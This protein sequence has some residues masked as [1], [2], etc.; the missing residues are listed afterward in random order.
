MKTFSKLE[1]FGWS[2]SV[3]TNFGGLQQLPLI[4]GNLEQ[5]CLAG[6]YRIAPLKF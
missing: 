4:V 5:F 6:L 2:P 1:A 3:N